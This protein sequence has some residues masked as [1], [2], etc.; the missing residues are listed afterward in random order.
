MAFS[1]ELQPIFAA[2]A[3]EVNRVENRKNETKKVNAKK[4]KSEKATSIK[5]NDSSPGDVNWLLNVKS[6]VKKYN[7]SSGIIMTVKKKLHLELLQRRKKRASSGYRR[8]RTSASA[9]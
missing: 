7:S 2:E 8:G 4:G 3:S 6:V 9:D 1:C 5:V